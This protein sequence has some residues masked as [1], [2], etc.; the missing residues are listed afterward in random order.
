MDT[1]V[2]P[3]PF[4][5]A[6]RHPVLYDGRGGAVASLALKNVLLTI[7]T[8]GVY[9]FWAKTRM[10]RYL[11]SH[12]GFQ[13]ERFEYTGTGVELFLGFLIVLVFFV[14]FTGTYSALLLTVFLDDPVGQFGVKAAYLLIF[15]FLYNYAVWRARRYR[16]S[17]S[18]WRGVRGGLTGSGWR[19]AAVAFGFDALRLL[20]LGLLYPWTRLRLQR[21][22]MNDSWFGDRRFH[23]DG[24]ARPLLASWLPMYIPGLLLFACVAYVAVT[25]G[26][27]AAAMRAGYVPPFGQDL[28]A[29]LPLALLVLL[30]ATAILYI[31]YRV[32]EFRLFAAYTRYESLGF[33]STLRTRSVL[34]RY[35]LYGVLAFVAY[36]VIAL[37]AVGGAIGL[38]GVQADPATTTT[39]I[40]ILFLV[41]LPVPSILR[42]VI[43][44]HG[45]AKRIFASLT[46]VGAFDFDTIVQSTQAKPRRGEGLAEMLDIGAV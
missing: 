33:E 36:I 19:F 41:I 23:F 45:L 18:Q 25:Y 22:M 39:V 43:V 15:M 46:V 42:Y 35:L 31:R 32:R 27:H 11:W 7:V 5:A 26:D 1:A 38:V 21:M 16:L 9:R 37:I 30:P 10:R 24:S 6:S 44:V 8:L 34:G 2:E 28:I 13:G 20:S 3:A 29:I 14:L 40:V 17:R 12:V 4:G